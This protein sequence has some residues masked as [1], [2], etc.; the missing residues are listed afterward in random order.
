[1]DVLNDAAIAAPRQTAH[2]MAAQAAC[3]GTAGLYRLRHGTAL[4]ADAR[5]ACWFAKPAGM[6]YQDLY[7]ALDP[8]VAAGHVGLWGRQMTLGPTPE[9]C[10][11]S[12]ER[13]A[14][15]PPLEGL[16]IELRP[17]WT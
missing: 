11:H 14:L 6:S 10:L 8:L 1:L 15:P 9:F 7:H 4:G 13:P 12:A 2:D 17:V 3:G 5:F 16:E